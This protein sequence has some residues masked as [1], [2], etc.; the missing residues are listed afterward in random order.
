[1]KTLL[2]ILLLIFVLPFA[3]VGGVAIGCLMIFYHTFDLV[4]A[5]VCD[6]LGIG[7]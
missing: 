6:I 4:S 3:L 2:K 5:V 1:M 7:L